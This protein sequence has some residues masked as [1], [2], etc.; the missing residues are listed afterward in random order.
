MRWKQS[1]LSR[2]G[3]FAAWALE[4]IGPDAKSAVPALLKLLDDEDELVRAR[5]ESALKKI[6]PTLELDLAKE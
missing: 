5:A 1:P 2:R 4:Q 6:D 3:Q